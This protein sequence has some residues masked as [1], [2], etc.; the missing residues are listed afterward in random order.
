MIIIFT[1]WHIAVMCMVRDMQN[2]IYMYI[3]TSK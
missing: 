3:P 1:K 2:V